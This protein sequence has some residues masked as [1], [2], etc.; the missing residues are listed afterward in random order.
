MCKLIP[1]PKKYV[2]RPPIPTR[3]LVFM[4]A[5][6]LYNNFSSRKIYSDLKFAEKAGYI[7]K[8]PHFNRLSDFL[9]SEG[10]YDLLQKLLTLTAMPLKK[11]KLD[12][13][14]WVG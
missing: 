6:K 10:T 5:M 13:R 3:D 14:I 7:K 4:T 9:N 11:N 2:G 8:A 12:I 1:E